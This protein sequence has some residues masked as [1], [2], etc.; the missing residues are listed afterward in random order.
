M[1]EAFDDLLTAF[2]LH[3]RAAVDRALD[4]GVD[5]KAPVRGQRPIDWLLSMYTR[6]P[7][8]PDCVRALL[9]RGATLDDPHLL[10]VLLDDAAGIAAMVAAEPALLAH[11]TSVPSAY[12]TLDGVSLLHVAAEFGHT[13]AAKALLAAGAPVD[14]RAAVDAHGAGGQTPLFH[15][16]NAYHQEA[17]PLLDLLLLHGARTDLL[18]ASLCWGRGQDW[19][20]TWFDVTPIGYA[21][22]GL[23]RQMH[24]DEVA[25]RE[26]IEA[27]LAAAGRAVPPRTNVP[28]RYLQPRPRA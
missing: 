5:A 6:S 10:P 19:E 1:T 25:I 26:R 8:L 28:N 4:R 9:A 16:V 17:R 7:R 13:R 2:E 20:T 11:R 22:C 14:A 27:L 24:R 21:Q 18:V 23:S 15:V 12:T 3:D